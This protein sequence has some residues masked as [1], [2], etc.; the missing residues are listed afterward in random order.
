M[1]DFKKD[2]LVTWGG[3]GNQVTIIAGPFNRGQGD[4]EWYVVRQPNGHETRAWTVEL[5][6]VPPKAGDTG[7]LNGYLHRWRIHHI[8]DEVVTLCRMI[9]S[10]DSGEWRAEAREYFNEIW[11]PEQ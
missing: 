11:R 7:R 1:S 4:G 5:K 6:P 8:D 9:S 10:S 2:Q 3:R